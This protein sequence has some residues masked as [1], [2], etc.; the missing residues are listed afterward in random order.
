MSSE[1]ER[2]GN[3]VSVSRWSGFDQLRLTDDTNTVIVTIG[4]I[5]RWDRAHLRRLRQSADLPGLVPVI[6]S[7]FASDEKPFV[8]VPALDGAATLADR[9]PP[10]G[11]EWMV[12]ASITESAARAAH[13]AHIRGLFHGSFS[14]DQIHVTDDDVAVSGI[15]LGLGGNFGG[16][17][18]AWVAP[19]VLEG[20]DATER[21]DV[22]S[23]GKI[24][25]ASLGGSME[26][27][28][29]SIRRLI[30]WS[31]SDTPEARPPSA[32]EFA[33]ILAEALGEDRPTF[34]P[35]F[36]PTVEATDLASTASAAVAAFDPSVRAD[37][38]AIGAA[39]AGG[40]SAM[41]STPTGT[42]TAV[43][44]AAA[45]TA[46]AA[47]MSSVG[48]N[49]NGDGDGFDVVDGESSTGSGQDTTG[50]DDP[51]IVEADA[52]DMASSGASS[53]GG[54][55]SAEVEVG[56]SAHDATDVVDIAELDDV[57][58]ESSEA[59]V[60]LGDDA[61]DETVK[62]DAVQTNEIPLDVADDTNDDESPDHAD[63]DLTAVGEA[64]VDTSDVEETAASFASS[65]ASDA[66]KDNDE[67]DVP[68]A[69]Q[70]DDLE[71][72][73]QPQGRGA[74]ASI[75]IGV[76]LALGLGLVLFALAQ[77][78]DG[79]PTE[80]ASDQTESTDDVDSST[81]AADSASDAADGDAASASAADDG[82]ASESTA[83]EEAA[84]DNSTAGDSTATGDDTA[85]DDP[86]DDSNT[87]DDTATD[88]TDSNTNDDTATDNTA[89]DN[90]D[91]TATDNTDSN[92]NDDTATDD[93][94]AETATA[95]EPA[96]PAATVDGPISAS[97][98]GVQL[99]HGIPG[100]TA[101]VYVD[102]E[103]LAPGF[104]AGT[105][106]GPADLPP[107]SYEVAIYAST[108][109]APEAENERTDEPLLTQ[110]MTIGS[111]PSTL[112][113][114]LDGDGEPALA[115]F[116]EPLEN[117]DPGTGR[118]EVRHLAAADGVTASIDGEDSGGILN[119][120]ESTTL[121]LDA[122]EHQFETFAADGATVASAT[123]TVAD[124][125]LA[126]ISLI[127]VAD[128]N[129]VEAVV[130]RF[131]GL[132]TAPVD[133]SGIPAGDSN[134]LAAGDD[135]TGLYLVGALSVLMALA[136]GLLMLR[137]SRRLL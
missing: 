110:V 39:T 53:K 37:G 30:M 127:G 88:N 82:A 123:L 89:T 118:V 97:E 35:A 12:C 65:S 43:G 14:P 76:L 116:V 26:N 47:A 66:A 120:G 126:S 38:T 27:V 112:V 40:A 31:S 121:V 77:S 69:R 104:T 10:T 84:A 13:E 91:N 137:R 58:G 79:E 24:L 50:S 1:D 117:V 128:D 45:G 105:I 122:G 93:D 42:A 100:V 106:A 2:A 131:S 28:P 73:L 99:L 32:L 124:G 61:V 71:K 103:A 134:L 109:S 101:D 75:M 70:T 92:T 29:R 95:V 94:S 133:D 46:A 54:G 4:S 119:P 52:G 115:S 36:I 44:A 25:E 113:A 48:G 3:S 17:Y 135:P 68:A 72:E 107:G 15:G 60:D 22:F 85:T 78:D 129:T 9:I 20:N 33:S 125:E 59:E 23:L 67:F 64:A 18:A 108:G 80:A 16:E 8:V 7:D 136:G 63:D 5:D 102:G 41:G 34:N 114:H 21:S 11:S 130:Q 51:A 87:S 74:A 96:A 56:D 49:G 19:E 81:D 86:S 98:A 83:D 111:E 132:A 6:D 57:A 90:T 55:A 62:N